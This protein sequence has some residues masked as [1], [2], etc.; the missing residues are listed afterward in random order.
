AKTAFGSQGYNVTA[1]ANCVN[2]QGS[3]TVPQWLAANFGEGMIRWIVAPVLQSVLNGSTVGIVKVEGELESKNL[4]ANARTGADSLAAL[5]AK[6]DALSLNV[7][8]LQEKMIAVMRP[9]G[10]AAAMAASVT[11]VNFVSFADPAAP[12]LGLVDKHIHGFYLC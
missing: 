11:K 2:F 4:S 5:I 12:A 7:P 1:E 3:V 6:V 10:P 8:A 9:Y